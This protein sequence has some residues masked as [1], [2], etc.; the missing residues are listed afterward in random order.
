MNLLTSRCTL[1][2]HLPPN[3]T[4]SNTSRTNLHRRI[5]AS[6][7]QKEQ[8]K[9]EAAPEERFELTLV[10]HGEDAVSRQLAR[11]TTPEVCSQLQIDVP[12]DIE[13]MHAFR[14]LLSKWS[15]WEFSSFPG[16]MS[17]L[18]WSLWHWQSVSRARMRFQSLW[19]LHWLLFLWL[20][21]WGTVRKSSRR[22]SVRP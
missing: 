18:S 15:L 4:N 13:V 9:H 12:P 14:A 11:A 1:S 8:T 21:C 10:T 6:P 17:C 7:R 19:R 3:A 5:T 20:S 22:G 16:S 2:L